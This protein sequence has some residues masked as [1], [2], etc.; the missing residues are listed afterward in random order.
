MGSNHEK[1]CGSKIL[2]KA[3][4]LGVGVLL[5]ECCGAVC[6]GSGFWGATRA[7]GC[8]GLL[9]LGG[10]FAGCFQ[11]VMTSKVCGRGDS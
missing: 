9:G 10:G 1:I 7:W 11:V 5:N 8:S 4:L 2:L 6:S 3:V